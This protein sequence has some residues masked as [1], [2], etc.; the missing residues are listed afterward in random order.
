METNSFSRPV[1]ASILRTRQINAV[2]E[3]AIRGD[4]LDIFP[5]ADLTVAINV[6]RAWGNGFADPATEAPVARLE[7]EIASR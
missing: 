3:S 7:Q 5:I 1:S 4:R 6:V 2:A